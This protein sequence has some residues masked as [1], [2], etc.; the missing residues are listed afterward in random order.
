MCFRV[1]EVEVGV[2]DSIF[3]GNEQ[4]KVYCIRSYFDKI[5]SPRPKIS[6]APKKLFISAFHTLDSTVSKS[7]HRSANFVPELFRIQVFVLFFVLG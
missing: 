4:Q 1:N 5:F 2:N 6:L 3:S 7:V